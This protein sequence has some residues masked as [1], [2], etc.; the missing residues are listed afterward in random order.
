MIGRL[1]LVS[2]LSALVAVSVFSGFGSHRASAQD[3]TPTATTEQSPATVS[4]SGQGVV[5]TQPDTAS[6]IVGVNI[7]DKTLSAAQEKATTAMTDVIAAL[8]DAG[9]AERDIQTVN[10]S[11]NILQNYD[12]NGNPATIEGFQVTNQVNVTVRDLTALGSILDTVVGKGA[13]AIYGISFYVDDPTAAA[14]QARTLAVQD[15]KKKADELAAAA[16]MTVGR[17]LSISE[18]SSYS[19][20]PYMGDRAEAADMASAV[21]IQAGTTAIQID[22]QVV[23]E[24][25]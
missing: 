4:V 6:V 1:T 2:A 7:I 8:K 10:Y 11:V 9:I 18:S 23:Y 19:P 22:V 3:S 14:T 13:N 25:V 21:P 15:A 17:I 5:T 16:G 20:M 24:L 12:S